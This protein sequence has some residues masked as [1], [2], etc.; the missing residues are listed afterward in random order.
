VIAAA[1]PNLSDAESRE[2][3]EFLT[4]YGDIFTMKYDDNG[5]TDRVH[6]CIDMREVRPIRQLPRR[7]SLAKRTQ[8]GEIF[9]MQRRGDTEVRQTLVIPVLIRKNGDFRFCVDCKKRNV[10]MKDCFTLWT[11]CQESNGSAFWT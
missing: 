10:T 9:D 5:R 7:L 8:V 4:E 3:E 11:C 6:Q 2:F 1:R